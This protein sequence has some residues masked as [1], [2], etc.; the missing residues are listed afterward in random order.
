METRK[1]TGLPKTPERYGASGEKA[2]SSQMRLKNLE[3]NEI[4]MEH[5]VRFY[6]SVSCED[7]ERFGLI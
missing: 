5:P 3:K 4:R 7:T 1:S 6:G 2:I